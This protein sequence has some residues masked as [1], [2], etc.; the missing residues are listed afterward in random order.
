LIRGC[1]VPFSVHPVPFLLCIFSVRTGLADFPSWFRLH[2]GKALSLGP[3][4]HRTRFLPSGFFLDEPSPRSPGF[5]LF[6]LPR[7]HR[8]FWV[9]VPFVPPFS[10]WFGGI[11]YYFLNFV[12]LC[13]LMPGPCLH[14]CSGSQSTCGVRGWSPPSFPP[15]GFASP[16]LS[17]LGIL[18]RRLCSR[19]PRGHGV[20]FLSGTAVRL[21]SSGHAFLLLLRP[22]RCFVFLSQT[23]VILILRLAYVFLR[24]SFPFLVTLC[25]SLSITLVL[26]T[27]VTSPGFSLALCSLP[28][29]FLPFDLLLPRSGQCLRL[30]NVFAMPRVLSFFGPFSCRFRHGS[31][32]P[33]FYLLGNQ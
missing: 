8:N 16:V 17:G 18:C 22:H 15:N 28:P 3:A 10:S 13:P 26:L 27:R 4:V 9:F 2:A 33:S 21:F 11:D 32:A 5:T 20:F 25:P 31:P 7:T 19:T 12:G 24:N 29:F 30:I 23:V 1:R 14:L 6:S